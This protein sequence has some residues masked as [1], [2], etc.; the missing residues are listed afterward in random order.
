MKE[1]ISQLKDFEASELL[2][3]DVKPTTSRLSALNQELDTDSVGTKS[4]S[5]HS[6]SVKDIQD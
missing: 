2:N 4:E 5:T 6:H 1:N 3:D